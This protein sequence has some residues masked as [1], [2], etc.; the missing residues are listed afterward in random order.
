MTNTTKILRL[1]SSLFLILA[2]GIGASNCGT[3]PDTIVEDY[4]KYSYL[5]PYTDSVNGCYTNCA[6][7]HD[8]SG[9]GTIE[10]AEQPTYNSCTGT[11]DVNCS[12]AFLLPLIY[13][14]D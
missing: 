6:T 13:P 8:T 7:L 11:C 10:P 14:Q 3:D 1:I 2:I 4:V 12:L 9:N 5:C